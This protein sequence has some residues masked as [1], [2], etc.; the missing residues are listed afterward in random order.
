MGAALQDLRY[1]IRLLWKKPGFTAIALLALALGIGANT[2]IFSVVNA[3]LLNPLPYEDPDQLVWVWGRFHLGNQASVSPPDFLDYRA[4]NQSF[5]YFA[6]MTAFGSFNLTGGAEPERIP[7]ASVTTDFFQALG[8]RPILG[9]TFSSE[10]SESGRER[11]AVIGQG[12]WQRRFG[13]DPAAVGQSLT[14]DGKNF[15][16]IGVAP[17]N[18]AMPQR[19]EIW[20]PLVL[21]GREMQVR[22]FHFLRPIAR[23]KAGVTIDQAQAD[24]DR[25]AGA[26]EKQYPDSNTTWGLRLVTLE[27]QMVG[28]VRPALLVLLGAVS[29]VLL[30]ACANVANLL[31]VRASARQKEIAIRQALGASRSRLARQ[32]LTESVTL[33]IAGGVL[34]LG[35]AVLGINLLVSSIPDNLPRVREIGLDGRVLGFTLLISLA[36]GIIFGLAPAF[37]ASSPDLNESLKEGGRGTAGARGN[38]TRSLL[39]V[40]EVALAIVLLIGAGLLIQS[41]RRLQQVDPGFNTE[42]LLTMRITLSQSKYSEPQ[43]AGAFFDQVLRRVESLPGV[44]AAG[45]T[46]HLPLSGMGG[47]TY[48]TIEGRPFDDPNQKVTAQNPWVSADFLQTM[49]I[50]LLKGRYFTEQ[51]TS[52]QP[53]SVIINESF[54]NSFFANDDP[55]GHYLIIDLGRPFNCEIVGVVRDIKQFSLEGS[56]GPMMY[57]PSIRRGALALAVRTT[58]DAQALAA[59]VQSEI[60]AVDKDQPISSIRTMEQLLSDAVAGPRFRTMLLTVFAAL[61]LSLAAVGI[62]GVISY[63]VSQRTH[64]IGIRIALGARRGDVFKMVLGQAGVLTLV[65]VGVGLAASLALTRFMSSLLFEVSAT[66]PLVFLVIPLTLSGV[67]LGACLAPA[68]RAT[69]VDP[70][71]AL[72][73]E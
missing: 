54:A 67:A 49:G 31:L 56:G 35:L 44:E 12:L 61:A 58:G 57:L 60:H 8:V 9:R 32:L 73:H 21:E 11:V 27:E 47:D 26:L 28:S 64:E 41:F 25:V 53:Q 18:T 30:I 71:V 39:V 22:R 48:F 40:S 37:G 70:M 20:V 42:N 1:A 3:V 59:A 43:Q 50:P 72:R 33:A 10:E 5:E 51:E 65:G 55:L 13:A 23:L 36:T 4:Q 45:T 16:V 68:R 52:Q 6:A 62:Y 17:T 19:A 69:R 63:T 34:G 14:L 7:G 15:T 29:F 66:D 38:R 2:A 24:L 46:T